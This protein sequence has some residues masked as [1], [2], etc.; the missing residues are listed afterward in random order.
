MLPYQLISYRHIGT[1]SWVHLR[2]LMQPKQSRFT[3]FFQ[4]VCNY[5]RIGTASQTAEDKGS[6]RPRNVCLQKLHGVICRKTRIFLTILVIPFISDTY[7][8]TLTI[9]CLQL[10]FL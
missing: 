10:Q 3:R 2:G 9:R 7:F 5:L 6:K 8:H 4:N 1:A